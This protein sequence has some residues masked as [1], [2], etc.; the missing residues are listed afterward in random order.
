MKVTRKNECREETIDMVETF[1]H[2]I[3]LFVEKIVFPE[4]GVEI[5]IGT[6]RRGERTIVIWRNKEH[7][8]LNQIAEYLTS[9]GDELK[10]C[11]RIFINGENNLAA[12]LPEVYADRI[13]IIEP[14][15]K[16]RMFDA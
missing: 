8:S 13:Y 16:K 6:T 14:E 2:L 1:N 3:G 11:R 5:V 15:F 4:D 7:E 12:L 9:L 10:S